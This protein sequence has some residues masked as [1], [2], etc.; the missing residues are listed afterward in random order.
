MAADVRA[1]VDIVQVIGAAVELRKAGSEYQGRCPF[2]DE[3]TPSFTVSPR[4][5]FY[6]CFGCGAH[7][8]VIAF[9][10]A[11]EGVDFI[12][13]CKHLGADDSYSPTGKP[14]TAPQAN[15]C[16]TDAPD[17]DQWRPLLPVPD[18]A[19]ALMA[20]N[21]WTVPVFNPKRGK[22]TRFKT[23]RADAYHDAEGR[24]LGYVLRVEFD[25]GKITPTVTWCIG[26]DGAMQWCV[27]PFPSPRPLQGLDA[28]AA[29]PDAP[30][31]LVEGEK[32]REAG[33]GAFAQYAVLTWPGGSKGIKY[34]DWSP[35][36]GRD[37]VLWPDADDAGREAML[38]KLDG[39]GAVHRG[40]AQILARLGVRSMRLI[41]TDGQ[42]RG[43]DVADALA[44]GW[45]P[46]QL[47]TWAAHR[48]VPVEVRVDA[49]RVVM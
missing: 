20:D 22:M 10:Q 25:N 18:S 3:R 17:P 44:D 38:G 15:H 4:K 5:Q 13:A 21:G 2:H 14:R 12:T 35:L 47:A 39:S 11:Y 45:T 7:G 49:E 43:W 33:A 23:S 24:L 37:V 16:A 30:V 26:P 19:P 34:T 32:C 40:I 28:L 41:D 8:D 31:L 36:A 29:R 27:R 1:R 42:P 9:V 48:V 6:H 46:K